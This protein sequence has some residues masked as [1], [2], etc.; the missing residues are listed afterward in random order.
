MIEL[1]HASLKVTTLEQEGKQIIHADSKTILWFTKLWTFGGEL[2]VLSFLD[3]WLVGGNEEKVVVGFF[4]CQGSF[5]FSSFQ[6]GARA[7]YR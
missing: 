7:R 2:K 4:F 1:V 3:R 5:E 6:D